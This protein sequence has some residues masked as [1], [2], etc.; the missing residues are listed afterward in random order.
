MYDNHPLTGDSSLG[1]VIAGFERETEPAREVQAALSHVDVEL[2]AM[3]LRNV[4]PRHVDALLDDLHGAG[5]SPRRETAVIDALG[6]LF[7]FARDR[8][9]TTVDPL[10]G[11][12]HAG[13][14]AVPTATLTMLALGARVASW[15]AVAVVLVFVLL[16]LVLIL[17][18]A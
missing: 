6:S 7:A 1:D 9:L 14:P 18:L 3:P 10:P 16:L 11:H 2:G 8:G 13:A 15:T 5:L 12:P 17:E 4:R